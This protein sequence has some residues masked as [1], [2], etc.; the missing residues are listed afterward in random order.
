MPRKRYLTLEESIQRLFEVDTDD[1]EQNNIDIVVPPETAEAS[2]EEEG[3]DNILNHDNDDLPSDTAGT[4]HVC[5]NAPPE[6]D[7]QKLQLS[8]DNKDPDDAEEMGNL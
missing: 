6:T 5:S 7:E 1:D 2:D 3:N 4:G 8:E